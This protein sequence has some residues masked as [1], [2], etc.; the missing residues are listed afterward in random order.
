MKKVSDIL[1]SS[2]LMAIIILIFA[3][4]IAVATF[5]E[6]DFGNQTARAVVYNSWWFGLMLFLGIVNLT[7]TIFIKRLYRI[8][9]LSIFIFHLSFLFILL[10]A[11]TTRYFG[12]EGVMHIREGETSN[13]VISSNALLQASVKDGNNIVFA[14]KSVLF[15]ALSDNHHNLKLKL[16][17][18]FIK[19][20]CTEFISHGIP[21]IADDPKGQPILEMV[22]S[23]GNGQQTN[24]IS[25]KQIKKIGNYYFN[26]NDTADKISGVNIIVKDSKPLLKL[27]K[28]GSFMEMASQRQ[29]VIHANIYY[30]LVLRSLYTFEG[31]QFVVTNFNLTGKTDVVVSNKAEMDETSDALRFKI[32]SGNETKSVLYFANRSEVNIPDIVEINKLKVSVAYGSKIVALPFTLH[33]NKF[34]LERYPGSNSPSW[35][36]SSI[37]LQDKKEN[38]I[39][40]S[41]IFMNNVLKYHGFRFYQSSYDQDQHGTILSVNY[42]FWGTFITYFGYILLALGI[43]LSLL[44][45]NSRFRKLSVELT[46]LRELRKAASI[47]IFLVVLIFAGPINLEAQSLLP[48][49]FRIDKK[50][51]SKFGELQIQDIKGRIKPVNTVSSEL[52]RKISRS[53]MLMGQTSDQVL[54]GMM[55]FPEYWQKAPV[56]KVSH[57]EI[58]KIL[59]LK[60]T[61]A[62]FLDFFD[63]SSSQ[64]KYVLDPYVNT[65]YQKKPANRS[66]FDTEVMRLDERVNICYQVYTGAFLRIFPR[67]N[68]LTKTWYSPLNAD[69]AFNGNDSLFAKGVVPVYFNEIKKSVTSGNW[70]LPDDA[71]EAIN[72]FQQK[73]GGDIVLS[74]SKVKMEVFYNRVGIFE[75]LGSV[76]GLVGF[77]L[78]VFQF[79]SVLNPSF[80]FKW[81]IKSATLLIITCFVLHLAGLVLRWYISG[82]APWSNA[83]ESLV[84][85]AFATILAG[86]IFSRK[87]NIT[88]SVTALMAWL[89]LFTAHLN[90]MDPEITN[91]GPVLKSYWLLIHVAIITASYGFLS[92]GALLALINLFFMIAQSGKRIQIVGY[93]ISELSIIIEMTLIVGL[94]MLTIG[95]FLG[96]VWANESWGRY[97][98]WD[99]KET[100]ALVSVLVYAFVA[101]MRMVP[102]LKGNYLFNLMALLSFSSIIMTYFGVNY[103]LSGLHSYAKGDPIPVPVFVY[104]TLSAV[105]I[106]A[107]F[108]GLQ[109]RKLKA[110][111]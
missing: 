102:G 76:Y 94:Y 26:F 36:E 70:N 51:A 39:E 11:A 40:K 79:I 80:R 37:T 2:R 87:S 68:D 104:Y 6:N 52:L 35:F 107:V 47:F 57:P 1:F 10:G 16:K 101:H 7:G 103:Y 74:S 91:L 33:L 88:L 78:L 60:D 111:V 105:F 27:S 73:F 20:E 28:D 100:W 31:I 55:V 46:K 29:E 93:I 82:H 44:N 86:I 21:T 14:E 58:Q 41:R 17:D 99:S 8:E 59:K 34:L 89:I 48:D 42:D 67:P 19:V 65:A 18:K 71:L 49:S 83:Y 45:K 81:L 95:T 62:S 98:G 106:I 43:V 3:V 54:L 22:T 63:R 12:F 30:P 24:I 15:S 75:R 53:E 109:Q 72:K 66:K 61:Y 13:Q 108:A 32:S 110:K 50:H 69:T 5:I 4:S 9:K 56:I 85:I 64:I 23:G 77:L 38:L 92:L 97:W 90:W 96:G 25:N 84:Y